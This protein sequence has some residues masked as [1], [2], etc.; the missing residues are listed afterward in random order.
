MD[1]TG[2]NYQ[3]GETWTTL[4]HP[5]PAAPFPS[6]QSPLWLDIFTKVQDW[7]PLPSSSS[8]VCAG[9]H[10]IA[11]PCFPRLCVWS[12]R[13]PRDRVASGTSRRLAI[14]SRWHPWFEA[15]GIHV[16]CRCLLDVR[17]Y[18]RGHRSDTCCGCQCAGS[19]KWE[20]SL[21]WPF[22]EASTGQSFQLFCEIL[23]WSGGQERKGESFFVVV[24]SCLTDGDGL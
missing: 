21:C 12:Q 13:P 11:H 18:D 15:S 19:R 5:P 2:K 17:I 8:S 10:V 7:T 20:N 9:S 6:H 22:Y 4:V 1:I 24:T 3:A 23:F 16:P 14:G